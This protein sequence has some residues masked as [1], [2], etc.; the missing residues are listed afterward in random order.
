MEGGRMEEGWDGMGGEGVGVRWLCWGFGCWAVG[1]CG[2]QAYEIPA[3][4]VRAMFEV[5]HVSATVLLLCLRR[6]CVA[7]D[8]LS[9]C[10]PPT[11]ESTSASFAQH[12][13]ATHTSQPPQLHKAAIHD[14]VN[15]H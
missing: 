15:G 6:L 14:D 8:H 13:K 12:L 4:M 1:R 2:G 5:N 7:T 9:E 10:G 11:C 3:E